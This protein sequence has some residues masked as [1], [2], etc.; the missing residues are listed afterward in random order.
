MLDEEGHC[1]LVDFGFATTPDANGIVRTLCGTP[2]YLSREQLNGKFTSGYHKCCDWW[3]L[4]II[5]YELMTGKTPFCKNHRESNYEIYLRILKNKLSFPRSWKDPQG[6]EL[7]QHLCHPN[8]DKRLVDPELIRANPYFTMPWD[9]VKTGK[10]VPP[11]VPKIKDEKDR[12]HYFRRHR[13][14]PP[15]QADT[16][17]RLDLDGF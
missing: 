13:E 9:K 8:M 4:G 7:V 3:A 15:D 6:K 10:L 2:A 17:G 1:K 14:Q 11:F 5:L 12:D 16:E